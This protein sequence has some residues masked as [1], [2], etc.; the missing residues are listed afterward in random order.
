VKGGV[1][2]LAALCAVGLVL[3]FAA[4]VQ[5]SLERAH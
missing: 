4:R 1:G 3:S 2:L 5:E